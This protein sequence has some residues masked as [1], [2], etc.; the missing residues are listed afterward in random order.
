MHVYA[1]NITCVILFLL[2]VIV[3]L[4]IHVL[5]KVEHSTNKCS[6]MT[7]HPVVVDYIDLNLQLQFSL[8]L[9]WSY[10]STS[11]PKLLLQPTF[12][13]CSPKSFSF[14]FISFIAFLEHYYLYTTVTFQCFIQ[15]IG[16]SSPSPCSSNHC[17]FFVQI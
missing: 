15:S 1:S 6:C 10:T 7:V 17:K 14:N 4:Y 2:I 11:S 9:T 5:L 16:N 13:L 12:L 8:L 3:Y